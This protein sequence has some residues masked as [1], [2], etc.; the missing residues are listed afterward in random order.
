[1]VGGL[2]FFPRVTPAG[3][4]LG[5]LLGLLQNPPDRQIVIR[6][7]IDGTGRSALLASRAAIEVLKGA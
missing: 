5:L 6:I 4:E 3:A 7:F 1:M 2:S